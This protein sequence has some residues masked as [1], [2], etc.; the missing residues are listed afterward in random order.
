MLEGGTPRLLPCHV[1][2]EAPSPEACIAHAVASLQHSDLMSEIPT[3]DNFQALMSR[4]APGYRRSRSDM[5]P[6]TDPTLTASQLVSQAAQADH[7]RRIV[8]ITK[9]YILPSVSLTEAPQAGD[10]D[11]LLA[12]WHLRLVSLWKLHFFSTLHE[13]MDA[14]WQVLES[15]RV[16]EGDDLCP[17]VDTPHVPFPMH[18][19][20]AQVLL[21]NDR[22]RGVQLL[23]K[24]MQRAK[25]ASADPMWRGRYIRVALLLSSLLVEMDALSAATSLVDELASGLGSA[26]PK[27]ALVL[28]R[29]YLQMCDMA[30]ASRMLSHAKNTADPADAALHDAILNH[31]TMTKFMSEPHADHEKLVVDD[32]ADVDQALTNTMALDAF[33]HGHIHESIQILERLMHQHPTT[34]TTTRAL[35]PNLLTLHSMGAKN[36]QEEKQ[37]V[38]RFLVQSA[39]DDPW[40]VDQRAG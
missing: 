40:F 10:M 28:C 39:G 25:E 1:M 21:Q 34:F 31:E 12:W 38:I 16:Y 23:W 18:V 11:T 5:F 7:W 14:L 8:S 24:H 6:L 4:Y 19:L 17:L 32:P 27:L 20:R 2:D 37:R 33:F 3:T 26:E 13:E 35:A 36:A 15:V 29:L 9:E 22:R 30:S